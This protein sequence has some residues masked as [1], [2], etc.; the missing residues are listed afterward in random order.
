MNE[1]AMGINYFKKNLLLLSEEILGLHGKRL[2]KYIKKY[3]FL[4]GRINTS[5]AYCNHRFVTLLSLVL[6]T[7]CATSFNANKFHVL[8]TDSIYV[9]C[10]DLRTNSDYFPI[11]H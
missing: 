8:P 11:Q 3:R 4:K 5:N 7:L 10:V 1:N 9:F 2:P 6:L